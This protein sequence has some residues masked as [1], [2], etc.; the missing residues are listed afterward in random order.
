VAETVISLADVAAAF[1]RHLWLLLGA[2]AA[3]L[4]LAVVLV[5]V[6]ERVYRAEVN[7]MPAATDTSGG[8]LSNLA[9]GLGGLIPLAGLNTNTAAAKN[10]AL[11]ILSSR[12]FTER[13][14]TEGDLLPVL[15]SGRWD[16]QAGIWRDPDDA[17]TLW[18]AVK[19]FDR[20]VRSVNEDS[21]TGVITV[22][23]EWRNPERATEWANQLVADLNAQVRERDVEEAARSIKYLNEQLGK[24]NIVELERAIY[25]LIEDQI[26]TIALANVRD[27]YAFRVIDPATAPDMDDYVYP[28]E[29][30]MLILG[31]AIGATLGVVFV[32]VREFG[33]G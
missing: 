7:M 8:A 21:S 5:I 31:L 11:A 1:R 16:S 30:V 20:N 15:Y 14:I 33:F 13:F 28:N 2:A 9:G 22:A 12:S 17:P 27:E 6:A 10:E 23:V 19:F 18:K 32:L 29:P 4:I 25:D 24:T 3:G 26:K